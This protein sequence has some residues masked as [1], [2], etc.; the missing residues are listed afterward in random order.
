MNNFNVDSIHDEK[1]RII[2]RLVN[3]NLVWAMGEKQLENDD[4]VK[5]Y[6]KALDWVME[7]M[8]K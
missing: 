4:E 8:E 6:I 5:G 1:M 2:D 3:S 7:N